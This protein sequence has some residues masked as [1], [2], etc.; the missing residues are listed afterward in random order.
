MKI[1]F[2]LNY[3]TRW[4]ESLYIYGD[5]QALGNNDPR[6]AMEMNLVA[7]DIWQFTLE[8]PQFPDVFGYRFVV[9]AP[10]QAW[11][12]EWGAPHIFV[13]GKGVTE[14][15]IFDSWHDM[16]ANK[17]FYSSAFVNGMLHRQHR[18]QPLEATPGSLL[19]KV[20]APLVQPWQVVAVSG[21]GDALGNWDPRKAIH[22]NDTHYPVWEV[23]LPLNQLKVPFEYKFLILDKN[24][25]DVV[26]WE[27]M[28]NRI[29]GIPANTGHEE[30][31]IDGLKFANPLENWKG[32]GTA[33]PVFSIRTKEDNGVG[34]FVDLKKM[35]DWCAVSGQKILQTLPINDTTMTRTWLDSYP[36]KANSIYALHPMYLRLEEVGRLKSDE[37]MAYY[38]SKSDELNN[39]KAID[40]EQVNN[41]KDEYL[42]EIFREAKDDTAKSQEYANFVAAN[43]YWLRPYA[44]WSALRD[45]YHTPD[46]NQWGDYAVYDAGKVEDYI[47]A[48]KDKIDFYYFTQYHLDRQLKSARDYAHSKGVV[49]KGDI[50]IG[51]SRFSVDAWIDPR[52]FNMDCQAGAPPDDFS[53]LGQN[54]GFPTYNWDEMAKDG[55]NWWRNRFR[56]MSEYFDAYRVD[57]ILGFFRIWQI[58]LDAVHGLLGYFNPALPFSPDELRNNYDF[59]IDTDLQTKPLILEWMLHD[60]F[61]DYTEEVKNEYLESVGNGR[62]R[63]K[64]YVDTQAKVEEAFSRKEPNEKNN[65]I[66]NAL[67][68]LIDDVLFIEDPYMRGHYHP[69]ISAQYSYQ[70]RILTD[71]QKWCFNRLYNDFFYHRH[72]DFWKGKAMWKL[73]PLLD[74]T[75]MLACAEDLGMIPDCVPE[76]MNDLKILSL[77]IQ[78]MPK[79]PNHE[80]GDTWNYPYYSVCTTS[81]HDMPGIRGWW[82]ADRSVT[83][84]YYN[85]VLHE[86]G[87]APQ[88]AEPWI[89]S[90]IVTLNLQSPSMLCILPLQ[91][92]LSTDG[93][94]RRENPADEQINEPA[95][96]RHYWR[97]RMHLDMDELMANATFN[98]AMK[99][100]INESGR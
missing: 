97:Y 2:N 73:P 45:D 57:H 31:V 55:F 11:R 29:Y 66:H 13:K 9:K 85:N 7:P 6:Q 44:A 99:D 8:L 42:H 65:K 47:R 19:L 18:D 28:N 64:D 76:V 56:K 79:N 93:S 83:Q 20:E 74:A 61:G 26:A 96:P 71:Y 37:R 17:P 34:D 54:W 70:Y 91:D 40:Y 52:L 48:N 51:I 58:P 94:I 89:C 36:Y 82:E 32:A 43:E 15:N 23:C 53:V 68:G 35:V 38:R 92:W 50:P 5:L 95:N 80:F 88:F 72:N 33:I 59:W 30:V 3:H 49:L 39:L 63:L 24:T 27:N 10:D 1:S 90:K 87:E 21:E 41:L 60:F 67:L 4:G 16:P 22:L 86:S 69:R 81:T 77:E 98:D 84:K 46:N 100:M 14:Y 78:R 25:G 75:S 62:Y 12:F